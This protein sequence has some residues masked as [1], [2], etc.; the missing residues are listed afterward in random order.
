MGYKKHAGTVKWRPPKSDW[1]S[2]PLSPNDDDLKQRWHKTYGRFGRRYE[3]IT[4]EGRSVAE[5]YGPWERGY[6]YRL[7]RRINATLPSGLKNRRTPVYNFQPPSDQETRADG[8]ALDVEDFLGRLSRPQPPSDD[9]NGSS[10]GA[11]GASG[12]AVADEGDD[13]GETRPRY[14]AAEKGKQREGE[15]PRGSGPSAVKPAV[16]RN[17][18]SP[19]DWMAAKSL[20][21]PP[22]PRG[23]EPSA[24]EPAT[25][26]DV[27]SPA[28]WIQ[29]PADWMTAKI[30]RLPP[31]RHSSGEKND[32]DIPSVEHVE[33]V[34]SRYAA[35]E[36][37]LSDAKVAVA[38]IAARNRLAQARTESGFAAELPLDG[39]GVVYNKTAGSRRPLPRGKLSSSAMERAPSRMG[40]P[41]S[42]SQAGSVM[43]ERTQSQAR[44][45]DPDSQ[46]YSDLV[47]ESNRR[48]EDLSPHS[49]EDIVPDT[50]MPDFCNETDDEQ[51]PPL[52]RL[53]PPEDDGRSGNPTPYH[54]PLL[55]AK[56]E[57]SEISGG[58]TPGPSSHRQA[59]GQVVPS[60]T[61]ATMSVNGQERRIS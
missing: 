14:T 42:S 19:A 15:L 9:A 56:R 51:L 45:P 12:S 41:G 33:D 55:R 36:R 31:T 7:Y 20:R 52:P 50:P 29:S 22:T 11:Q 25:K 28:E 32:Q 58:C 61:V 54:T 60:T 47:A 49:P 3:T 39:L 8:T 38:E 23:S 34:E 27:P 46:E 1:W 10:D 59:L 2:S 6:R 43:M 17:L 21:M 4:P 26:R 40:V 30:L 44:V 18:Q 35:I 57:A 37:S 5:D 24:I 16:K 53:T 48:L 13:S